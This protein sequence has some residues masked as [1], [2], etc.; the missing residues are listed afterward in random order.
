MKTT[1][2][3]LL[4]LVALLGIS[5]GGDD[6]SG[7][8]PVNNSLTS[9]SE[10]LTLDPSVAYEL[11]GSMVVSGG[12]TLTIPAG[13]KI[14]ADAGGT[15]VYIAVEQGS[16]ININ[17]TANNPV[18]MSSVN[19]NQGD[20]GGLILCGEAVTTAGVDAEAEVA[21]LIYGGTDNSDSS[22]SISHLVIRGTGAAI[23]PE[24]EFNGV[25][26]YA[27]GSGTVVNNVAVINGKDDG[28]EFF[29]G[30]VSVTNLYLKNNGDDSVDWTEGW[31]GT[32]TNTYILHENAGFS[33]AVEGDKLDNQPVFNN[34]TA[35]SSVDGIGL[36]FKKESGAKFN[37]IYMAGYTVGIDL[38]DHQNA[39]G[40]EWGSNV[41]YFD[42]V[43]LTQDPTVADFQQGTAVDVSSWTWK[44]ATL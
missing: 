41:I 18:V 31:S 43:Q 34:F 26:F 1:T 30:T 15:Q 2:V 4:A 20:W 14:T 33:T 29:G 38:K 24:S 19:G 25:T 28:V 9:I 40:N 6:D 12:A 21:G 37:N 23:N 42:G 39:D 22:G 5:C 3:Y 17:G 16:K 13:T 10:D 27:V 32:I 7:P 36:Q 11:N 35:F 44:D 8:T